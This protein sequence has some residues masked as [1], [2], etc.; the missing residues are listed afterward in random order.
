MLFSKDYGLYFG[1]VSGFN[2]KGGLVLTFIIDNDH[3][4]V[5]MV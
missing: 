4:N 2:I 5:V 3:N 1:I